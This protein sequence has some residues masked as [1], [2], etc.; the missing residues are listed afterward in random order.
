M[1]GRAWR[2]LFP[3][4][5]LTIELRGDIPSA[6]AALRQQIARPGIRTLCREGV[7][8]RVD[9][10]GIR[11]RY[12][13]PWHR[14]DFAPEFVGAFKTNEGRSALVGE[15]R[16]GRRTRVFLGFWIGFVVA[17]WALA[18]GATV[19]TT[20]PGIPMPLVVLV[21]P[22]MIGFAVAL[23]RVGRYLGE[24]NIRRIE[25]TLRRAVGAGNPSSPRAS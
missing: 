8:G 9:E 19:G 25:D 3:S 22:F 24:S 16:A 5:P 14:N 2:W 17:G 15:F 18:F 12:Q 1:L 21:P 20:E 7:V 4:Q 11:V 10:S 13:R 23:S 6:V